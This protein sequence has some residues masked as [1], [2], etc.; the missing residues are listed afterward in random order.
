MGMD[1]ALAISA[2]GRKTLFYTILWSPTQPFL[3]SSRK[4][5]RCVTTLRTA[6]L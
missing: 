5:E 2:T 4:E 1:W 3:G 6:A